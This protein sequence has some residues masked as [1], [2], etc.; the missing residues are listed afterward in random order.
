MP[1]QP[2][3][4]YAEL[5]TQ[6][7]LHNYRYHVLDAP[8]ISDLEY[9]RLLNE[10]KQI[11]AEHP[12]WI[13]LDSPTQRA[14]A[15]PADRF[16]K[17]RHPAPILSLANAFGAEDARAWFERIQK[18]DDRVE[19]AQF[20]VEPKID[21]LSVVL[22]YR[23]G[24]F[25]QG[26]TRGNGEIGEDITGN[27][28]TVKAIPL[29]IPVV[30]SKLTAPK[31]LVV[32]GEA[33]IPIKD[34]ETLNKKL[35]EAGERTY[36]NPRNTA[37]G[38]LR[39]LDP[40]LTA[41]RPITLLVYQIVHAEGGAVPTSQW[42]VLEYLKALGFPVANVS[43]RFKALEAA[44]TY[45]ETFNQG[46]DQ[47]PYEADGMVIKL[48]DL[49][50]AA[51][52]GFVGKDPRGAIAYKFPAREV[53]TTLNEIGVAVGR[54][55]VLTPY[56][57]LEP[58]EI[59]GVTVERATLHN[60]DFI[61]EKDIRV[62]DRVLLKRA[63]EVIPYVIGPVTDARSGREKKFKPPAKCPACGQAV[64]HLEG[65]VAWYCV[66]AACP[67]QLLRNIEHFVSRGALDIVGLGIKIV[68]QLIESGL[69]EDAADLFALQK[70]DLLKLEGFAEKKAENLLGAIAQAKGQR[71]N[72]V[73]IALGIR[74]VGEVVA[75][76]LA[77]A[78]G[79]LSALAQASAEE[80][81]QIE[82][83]GPNI[84]DSIVDWFARPAN[85][86]VLKK[87]KSAGVDPQME[88]LSSQNQTGKL[89]GL[90]FVVTGTL[91]NFSREAAKEFIESHGGKTVDSVSKKTSY[92]VLGEAP[93]SKFEKA[94]TLGVKIIDEAG[95]RKLAE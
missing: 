18:L 10:L 14:G 11:E 4:R 25:V 8:L 47:L 48:D 77:R 81:Q 87:L 54:T 20:V 75:N 38:S 1:A 91:P 16:E 74:G 72:R 15:G 76:D 26:A 63:G 89:T 94:K 84:A 7:N 45:T 53:T 88:K 65:E 35:E 83:L 66:N 50:L 13:T 6:L 19:Q 90:T 58:V 86:K 3:S 22:H 82:G 52:L 17:I 67:A 71:L 78:F 62:G 44:L 39:Q 43:K 29:R 33:F 64:E 28:R 73:I 57:V 27:L 36:Q 60:F 46:R 93:G 5:K 42:E 12:D 95:L 68:E 40:E 23:D 37:A 2:H 59:N 9:D 32:R 79:S 80:L 55:G 41:T 92:L 51:D 56:A 61:A 24:Q 49:K 30:N 85:R 69:I 21:G 70:A 34:F 31:Y